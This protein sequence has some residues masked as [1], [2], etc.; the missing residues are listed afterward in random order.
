MNRW[1]RPQTETFHDNIGNVIAVTVP[2]GFTTHTFYDAANRAT[3]E[4]SPEVD[5][6]DGTQMLNGF[7]VTN[8]NFDGNGNAL[9]V[10]QG[11]AAALPASDSVPCRHFWNNPLSSGRSQQNQGSTAAL[12]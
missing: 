2:R 12:A 6:W 1:T 7:L 3:H 9:S 10:I 11:T 8:T 5:Y 4:F